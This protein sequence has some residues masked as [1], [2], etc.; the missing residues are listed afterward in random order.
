M[1][2]LEELRHFS[3]LQSL[4]FEPF[5]SPYCQYIVVT[6][7]GQTS[8][9]SPLLNVTDSRDAIKCKATVTHGKL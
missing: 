1:E 3:S 7:Y 6:P 9:E 5:F 4:D 2:L 8:S